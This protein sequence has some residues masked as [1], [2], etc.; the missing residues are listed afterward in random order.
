[1]YWNIKIGSVAPK[2]SAI[3]R[4]MRCIEILWWMLPA[5]QGVRL[6]E[7]WDVLKW[8]IH[9]NRRGTDPINRN[10]RCIEIGAD[11]HL[12]GKLRL[13]LIETWD[14]LK[15]HFIPY[16]MLPGPWLIETWDVLKCVL[17]QDNAFS[18]FRLIETWDVLKLVFFLPLN[19]NL[20]D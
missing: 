14:V 13:R 19:F 15:C 11:A 12:P 20:R 7:T 2:S 4:N 6:I 18:G 8:C 5:S 1:M 17:L 3:N 10:M 9:G 16:S